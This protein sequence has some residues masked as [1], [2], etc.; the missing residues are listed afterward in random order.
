MTTLI[1]I[2]P[3]QMT[4]VFVGGYSETEPLER[5][6]YAQIPGGLAGFSEW[7]SHKFEVGY[8]WDTIVSEKFSTRPMS[9]QYKLEELEP[10]RIEGMLAWVF[11]Q[12]IVWQAPAKMVLR[13]GST[14]AERKRKSDDVLRDGGL[15]LTGKDVDYK[16]ANDANAAAK[17]A[18]AYMRSIKHAPTL[19]HYFQR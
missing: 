12:E 18:L 15:W 14:Q 10:I 16:D 7:L 1:A 13:Q 3:G 9:R 5:T 17:H 19:A 4:G 11:E 2:D 8:I 6:A